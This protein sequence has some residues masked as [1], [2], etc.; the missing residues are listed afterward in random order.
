M[1]EQK[2]S[3]F[4]EAMLR[5]AAKESL[6]REMASIPTEEELSKT[7]S[8]TK[9][10]INRMER[11]FKSDRMRTM[12]ATALKVA[13]RVAVWVCIVSTSRLRGA[14]RPPAG[15]RPYRPAR[16]IRTIER[17]SAMRYPAVRLRRR[18]PIRGCTLAVVLAILL[19]SIRLL[20]MEMATPAE[21]C[22]QAKEGLRE[23][24]CGLT[25]DPV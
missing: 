7:Q 16:S 19:C 18:L 10:H 2:H 6:R 15:R 3:E 11:M 14:T 17:T 25:P 23:Q 5:Y 9:A 8:F 4:T 24:P 13:R 20:T 21:A 12:G 1:N 22:H